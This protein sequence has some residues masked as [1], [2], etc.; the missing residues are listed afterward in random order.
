MTFS[1]LEIVVG[2]RIDELLTINVNNSKNSIEDDYP[3]I[4]YTLES[5]SFPGNKRFDPILTC[6]FWSNIE[7]SST[8][9]AQADLLRAGFDYFYYSDL[10][11]FFKS[12]I[13]FM[14]RIPDIKPNTRRIQQRYVLHV[15]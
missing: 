15:Y 9:A 13:I 10:N 3:C 14:G 4:N 11:G 7:D 12:Y 2:D 5:I 1:Q 6:D 8:I